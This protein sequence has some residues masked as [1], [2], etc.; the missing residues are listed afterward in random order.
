MLLFATARTLGLAEEEVEA[1]ACAV[2]LVHVYSLVHDDLPAM[3][4]DDLRRGKPTCHKAYDEATAVLVG[5]ALQP[6]AFQ[7]LAR[8]P[9]LPGAPAI[10]LRLIE[11]LAQAS[12][13]FGMAGG[14]AID[15]AVQGKQLGIAQ[16]EEMHAR[17]TG[18]LIRACVLM[19]A[20]CAPSLDAPLH[21]ALSSFATPIGL[22]FQ[23]QD[24]LLDVL[25]DPSTLGKATGADR[26]RAKPTHPAVIGI[27]A[28]Q[29]R[30]RFLHAQ[31]VEAL[32]P[33]GH[34]AQPLRSLADWLLARRF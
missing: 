12:G 1:A 3:D 6:L 32:S 24:D 29:E 10:R 28:S 14:Q 20:A 34:R 9:A 19:A 7:L 18:A 16:V 17:K 8:D 27:A 23:I 5:D 21:E 11:L 2:E 26:E 15:L 33:F 30:V 13:T 4:D 22:A 31:A 25:G